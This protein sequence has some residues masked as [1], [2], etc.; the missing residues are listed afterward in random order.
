MGKEHIR[1]M[2]MINKSLSTLG[3]VV[4]AL[5]TNHA[6]VPYRDSKLTRLLQDSLGVR[7]RTFLIATVS[8]SACHSEESLSTLKFADRAREVLVKLQKNEFSA[9]SSSLASRLQCEI[10]QLK[11]FLHSK[12]GGEM[13]QELLQLREENLRLRAPHT[14]IEEVEGLKQENK[15][16][17][18][19]LQ[20]IKDSGLSVTTGNK[21]TATD[22]LSAMQPGHT[23]K[24][25]LAS[26]R[27]REMDLG[28]S[29]L[30]DRIVKD[31]RCAVCTLRP[32]CKHY[33]CVGNLPAHKEN[34][35]SFNWRRASTATRQRKPVNLRHL[36]TASVAEKRRR[37]LRETELRLFKLAQIETYREEKLQK[38]LGRLE[39]QNKA[40]EEEMR[41]QELREAK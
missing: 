26:W 32:P 6:H 37:E 3:Q 17:R 30:K 34:N 21:P 8:P 14:T 15:R 12:S 10:L 19:Q 25:A 23:V 38:E 2:T 35:E 22:V 31:K 24:D 36:P 29:A 7:T 1:E 20:S 39:L 28:V 9:T 11:A 16:L 33:Q 41:T 13:S 40:K 18:L 4:H 5:G 27:H